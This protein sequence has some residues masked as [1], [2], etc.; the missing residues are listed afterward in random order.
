MFLGRFACGDTGPRGADRSV[1]N[2]QAGG[3]G[4]AWVFGTA[5]DGVSRALAG[6]GGCV[7]RATGPVSRASVGGGTGAAAR[8]A[9]DRGAGCDADPVWLS[10]RAGNVVFPYDADT[11]TVGVRASDVAPGGGTVLRGGGGRAAGR[12]GH[13]FVHAGGD[14]SAFRDRGESSADRRASLTA[15][16][17]PLS[18]IP[19]R[20][21]QHLP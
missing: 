21:P 6:A 9:I 14:R 15:L 4:F 5:R 1:R 18:Q 10:L 3:D 20:Q 12:E 16:P 19:R 2:A 7:R 13:L 17:A 8:G 11:K